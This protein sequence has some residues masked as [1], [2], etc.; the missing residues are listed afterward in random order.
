M[1]SD[2]Q[3]MDRARQVIEQAFIG[4]VTTVDEHGR[5]Q[6]RFMA[7]VAE[8]DRL[9]HLFSLTATETRKVRQIR[10]NANVCWLFA[11]HDYEHVVKVNGEATFTSTSEIPMESWNS[12]VEYADAYVTSELRDKAHFAFYVLV[13]RVHTIELLSPKM[14]LV[15]PH[16]VEVDHGSA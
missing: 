11:D 14:G 16:A 9:Q 1:P 2:T 7:A 4:A 12:L 15:T 8:S 6:S 10:G 3:I 13:T 5:P